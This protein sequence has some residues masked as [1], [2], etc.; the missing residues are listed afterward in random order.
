MSVKAEGAATGRGGM[1][2][3]EGGREGGVEGSWEGEGAGG[4]V[5][6]TV[7]LRREGQRRV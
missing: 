4:A 1:L 7:G 2:V 5:A 3:R 6:A